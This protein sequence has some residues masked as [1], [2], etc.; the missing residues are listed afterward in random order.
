MYKKIVPAAVL[1]LIFLVSCG[2]PAQAAPSN[3]PTATQAPAATATNPPAAELPA[4]IGSANASKV[5]Q[6][7]SMGDPLLY[8]L[9]ISP[10]GKWLVENSSAGLKFY[11]STMLTPISQ[12]ASTQAWAGNPVFS[13][14]GKTVG[15]VAAGNKAVT[16]LDFATGNVIQT[17]NAPTSTFDALAFSPDGKTLATSLADKTIDLWDVV[18]GKMLFTL[19]GHTEVVILLVF[20]PDGKTLASTSYDKTIK[21]WN[22]ASGNLLFTLSGHTDSIF[23]AVFTPDGK[24]LVSSSYDKTI[25]IWDVAGGK[26]IKSM[27]QPDRV[28]GLALSPDGKTLASSSLNKTVTLWDISS[29]QVMQTLSGF[30]TTVGQPEFY[31]GWEEPRYRVVRWNH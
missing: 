26:L 11:D 21:L 19:S 3:T 28:F 15:F 9:S 12:P 18:S 23:G 5:V 4:P 1:I 30:S 31:P 27:P 25:K 17:L 6:V 29:W 2:S 20:S 14:D 7:A 22:V 16:L 10:D 13:P 8:T 24:S